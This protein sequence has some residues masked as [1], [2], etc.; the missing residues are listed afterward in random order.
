MS[1]PSS[2]E[3]RLRSSEALFYHR[4][5]LNLGFCSRASS[6]PA[7][8]A[9]RATPWRAATPARPRRRAGR[10]RPQRHGLV[11]TLGR[12]GVIER[13]PTLTTGGPAAGR[14]A[15]RPAELLAELP[16]PTSATC[17]PWS[18]CAPCW[19]DTSNSSRLV[20]PSPSTTA[21]TG[22]NGPPCRVL[23]SPPSGRRPFVRLV[24]KIPSGLLCG[25]TSYAPGRW[26][27]LMDTL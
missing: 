25:A 14:P 27:S 1:S 18:R 21:S 24:L 4:A 13:L 3:L 8:P 2:D 26:A 12:D 7:T 15:R 19:H 16:R 20:L 6:T 11:D 22:R 5:A 9:E 17:W 10:H 23:Q